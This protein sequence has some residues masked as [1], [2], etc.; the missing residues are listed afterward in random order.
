MPKRKD[1]GRLLIRQALA[2][3]VRELSTGPRLTGAADVYAHLA[4]SMAGGQQEVF[5][6]LLVDVKNAIF[7]TE[8]VTK[9]TLD[10][11]LVHPRDVFR[12]AIRESAAALVLAHNHPSGDPEPSAEDIALTRRL[13]DAGELLG[14]PVLDHVVIGTDR[15]VSLAERGVV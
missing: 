5:V 15:Y 11:S 3:S 2:H 4:P 1:S 14:I 9:G 6:V 13:A 12:R 8:F 10:A 7:A